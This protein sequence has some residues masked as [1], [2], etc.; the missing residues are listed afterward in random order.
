ME[1]IE[2]FKS[3]AELEAYILKAE[4]NKMSSEEFIEW[5]KTLVVE[6]EMR[7]EPNSEKRGS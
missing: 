3:R 5:L 1:T 2:R 4:V 6:T 7:N